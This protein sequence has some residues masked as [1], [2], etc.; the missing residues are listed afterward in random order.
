[1]LE[2]LSGW[3]DTPDRRPR[4]RLGAGHRTGSRTREGQLSGAP[5]E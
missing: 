5:A 4:P 3:G 2:G 1:M